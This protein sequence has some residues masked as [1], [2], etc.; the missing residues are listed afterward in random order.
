MLLSIR[1]KTTARALNKQFA[2]CFPYLKLQF[3]QQ[4]HSEGEGSAPV[5]QL[6][7]HLSLG[8]QL[9][10]VTEGVFR[11]TPALSVGEFEQRLQGEHGIPVQVFRKSGNLWLQTVQTDHL[12]LEQQNEK[13]KEASYPVRQFNLHTLFL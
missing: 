5:Q 7:M 3:F 11:F 9:P 1:N 12:S 13:G 4:R 2:V 10:G 8:E 6:A